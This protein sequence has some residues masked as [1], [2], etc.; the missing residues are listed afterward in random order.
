MKVDWKISWVY[1][2]WEVTSNATGEVIF[3]GSKLAT[4]KEGYKVTGT[5]EVPAGEYTVETRITGWVP[6]D[7]KT[8]QPKHYCACSDRVGAGKSQIETHTFTVDREN[9]P[10]P[11]YVPYCGH[12]GCSGTTCDGG[13][14]GIRPV[15]PD[16]G[17][18]E[19]T[20]P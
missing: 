7:E 12:D 20:L 9:S 4:E 1:L 17:L 3:S 14:T 13:S 6:C 10:V 18:V 11:L 16:T 15:D 2:H 19:P 5:Y 8:G